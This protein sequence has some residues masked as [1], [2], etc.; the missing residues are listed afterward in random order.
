MTDLYQNVPNVFFSNP[1]SSVNLNLHRNIVIKSQNDDDI[2]SVQDL[3]SFLTFADESCAQNNN[4]YE[5]KDDVKYEENEEDEDKDKD[6]DEEEEE[7]MN[8]IEQQTSI[9]NISNESAIKENSSIDFARDTVCSIIDDIPPDNLFTEDQD[10]GCTQLNPGF[11][12]SS[13]IIPTNFDLDYVALSKSRL[14]T[15]DSYIQLITDTHEDDDDSM[16]S[17]D[18]EYEDEYEVR[19]QVREDR[20]NDDDDYNYSESDII[21]REDDDDFEDEDEAG[22][23]EDEVNDER[24]CGTKQILINDDEIVQIEEEG[25]GEISS[26]NDSA[27]DLEEYYVKPRRLD[28]LK[29]H[30]PFDEFLLSEDGEK[31]L[32]FTLSPTWV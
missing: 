8:L 19:E 21:V 13:T 20:M 22:Q 28:S 11:E 7:K 18:H 25:P 9:L 6:K 24:S 5:V 14:A 2:V 23:S 4:F 27:C 3:L 29:K 17:S 16:Q 30:I 31:T 1:R 12:F 26:P 15:I 32:R 10:S